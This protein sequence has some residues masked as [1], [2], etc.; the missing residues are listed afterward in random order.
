[1]AF[2]FQNTS[3]GFITPKLLTSSQTCATDTYPE[4]VVASW[5]IAKFARHLKLL[6]IF[7]WKR[8]IYQKLG[9]KDKKSTTKQSMM[10]WSSVPHVKSYGPKRKK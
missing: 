1:M 4:S 9:L 7:P 2:K 6:K 10:M 5:I 8:T 3:R